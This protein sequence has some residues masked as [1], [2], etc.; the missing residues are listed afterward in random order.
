ANGRTGG[1]GA[2]RR[3]RPRGFAR[4][5]CVLRGPRRVTLPVT[6]LTLRKLE[7]ALE[8]IGAHI[9]GTMRVTDARV[10]LRHGDHRE[11]RRIGLGDFA[12]FER[13]RNTRVGR[14]PNGVSTGDGTVFRV[15]VVVDEHA[16][17]LFLPPFAGRERRHAV[18]DL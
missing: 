16:V 14:R 6:L 3:W 17:S 5:F 12:P 8:G 7:Q 18:L 9:E 2:T 13:R 1:R 10:A 4:R 11:I 15:L